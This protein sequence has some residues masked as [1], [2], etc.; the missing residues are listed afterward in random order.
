MT[1]ARTARSLVLRGA[2]YCNSAWHKNLAN[3]STTFGD[4]FTAVFIRLHAD[5][6]H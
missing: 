2:K 4:A 1:Q 5:A 6:A 3:M